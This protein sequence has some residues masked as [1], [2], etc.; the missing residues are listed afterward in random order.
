MKSAKKPKKPRKPR[1]HQED[2]EAMALM[3][4]IGY[5]MTKYPMLKAFYHVPNGGRMNVLTGVRMKRKGV[6]PGVPD[7]NLD[8]ACGGYHGLRIELKAPKGTVSA[9]QKEWIALLRENGFAAEVCR[10]WVRAVAT[11][12]NYIASQ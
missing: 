9:E 6:K 3:R 8:Y 4:W 1:G 10:G 2:D 12:E 11:I 7:Y 5:N